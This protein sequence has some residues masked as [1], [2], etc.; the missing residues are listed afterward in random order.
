[1]GQLKAKEIK[2]I[3]NSHFIPNQGKQTHEYTEG[4]LVQNK[5]KIINHIKFIY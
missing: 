5:K 2:E 3:T 1:M 4:G